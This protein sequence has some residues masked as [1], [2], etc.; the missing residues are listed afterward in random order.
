MIVTTLTISRISVG[1]TRFATFLLFSSLRTTRAMATEI[2]IEF[3]DIMICALLSAITLN[4][5]WL[6]EDTLNIVST[7]LIGRSIFLSLGIIFF[8]AKLAVCFCISVSA[9]GFSWMA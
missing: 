4:F 1:I 9:I 7:P 2:M 5:W 3:T 8:S 6:E